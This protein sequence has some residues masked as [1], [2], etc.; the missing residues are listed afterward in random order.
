LLTLGSA[1]YRP[2]RKRRKVNK[3]A[4]GAT[5]KKAVG[6]GR[7]SQISVDDLVAAQSVADAFG[8]TAKAIA[9]LQALKRFEY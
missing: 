9:A 4:E 8:G 2:L 6:D 1:V 5:S 3:T 7:T